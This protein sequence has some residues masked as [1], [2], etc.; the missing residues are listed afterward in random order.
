VVKAE[1]HTTNLESLC[2][3]RVYGSA[4][5]EARLPITAVTTLVREPAPTGAPPRLIVVGKPIPEA[6]QP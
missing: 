1:F 2:C 4:D 6:P 5:P 3:F